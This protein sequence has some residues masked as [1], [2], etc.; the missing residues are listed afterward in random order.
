[1]GNY[2]HRRQPFTTY[3]M[4]RPHAAIDTAPLP[5]RTADRTRRIREI[6]L[7]TLHGHA[8]LDAIGQACTAAGL[9]E[10]IS[11]DASARETL[12]AALRPIATTNYWQSAER[13]AQVNAL[14]P[15]G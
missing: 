3:W 8:S 1:M 13:A 5:A 7:R 10:G 12:K 14:S 15:A 2:P 6:F 11:T 9:L 4:A